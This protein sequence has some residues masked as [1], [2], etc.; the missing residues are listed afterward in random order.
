MALSI[1]GTPAGAVATS[2]T[3]PTHAIG[4]IIIVGAWNGVST[5]TPAPPAAGGTVP[6]W[7]DIDANAGS[8]GT[9]MRTVYFVATATNHT[10]GTWTNTTEIGA[11]VIRGQNVATPFGGHAESGGTAASSTAPAVTM[12]Q[13]DG[14]S[15]LLHWHGH[16]SVGGAWPAAPA[17]YTRQ[18]TVNQGVANGL[19]LNT[20]NVTTSDGSIVQTIAGASSVGYHGATIEILVAGAVATNT[21]LFFSMFS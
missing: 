20:K 8:V 5:T 4:D 13:T 3:L 2:V 6:A 10:T 16:Q 15:M 1:I 12:T 14:T 7:V 21:N 18:I 17:G 11:I 9:A 19:V